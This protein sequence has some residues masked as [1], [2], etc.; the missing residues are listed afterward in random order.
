MCEGEGNGEAIIL[1]KFAKKM[2]TGMV[3][4]TATFLI[5]G[6]RFGSCVVASLGGRALTA[7]PPLN[8]A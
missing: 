4:S 5:L 3:C 6:E 2:L 1:E 7:I 8:R